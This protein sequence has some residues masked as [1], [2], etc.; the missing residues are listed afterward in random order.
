MSFLVIRKFFFGT[1]SS[2]CF[3]RF[4]LTNKIINRVHAPTKVNGCTKYE[5]DPLNIVGCRVVSNKGE[6]DG[7]RDG[8]TMQGTTIPYG[9]NGLRVKITF[10]KLTKTSQWVN[11][12][13]W[14]HYWQVSNIRRTKSQH[15][16]D[17]RTVF[18]LSLPNPLKPDVKSRMKM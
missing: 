18:R 7:Q 4:I 16:N 12:T 8:Q 11:T 1:G 6:T 15:S 5:Q 17:S 9:P 3:F 14:N 13:G 2:F 10:L